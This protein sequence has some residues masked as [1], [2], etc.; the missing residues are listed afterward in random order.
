[1]L[2]TKIKKIDAELFVV[3][4]PEVMADAK[5]GDH[6]HFE[7]ITATITLE[8]GFVGTG[9]TYTGGRGGRS[10]LALII[11]DLAPVLIGCDG[12]KVAEAHDLMEWHIHYVGRGGI[13]SFSMSAIDIALWDLKGK[14][15]EKP[16]SYLAGNLGKTTKAYCG[17][18]DLNFSVEKL[19]ANVE[20]Y[21]KRGFN[22]IKIKIGRENLKEDI[23]RVSAVRDMLTSDIAFMV[24]ANYSLSVERAIV[25]AK[26]LK[27]F[28]I[29]WFEEPIIPDDYIGYARI[30][31]ETGVP[32]EINSRSFFFI[33]TFNQRG[34]L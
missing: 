18:I 9:Y 34:T 22:G 1:M 13:S 16:L 20:S 3:P 21:L 19:L 23:E 26:A 4:L 12:S 2:G 5:H 6:T 8:N 11:Y 31:R 29:L 14:M 28:D 10:I 25:T 24:D 32:N 33:S 7:L 15:E 27:D 17:G 30:S